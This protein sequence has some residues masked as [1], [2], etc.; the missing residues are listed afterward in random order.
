[1]KTVFL[2]SLLMTSLLALQGQSKFQPPLNQHPSDKPFLF[3]QLPEKFSVPA[4][5]LQSIFSANNNSGIR[6]FLSERLHIEGVVTARRAI[7]PDQLSINIRCTNYQDALLNLSRIT[8]ADGTY[9]YIGR[10]VSLR[11]GDV[12]LLWAD[13][14]QY[15]FVRQKQLLAMVE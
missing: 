1:M 11:H 8:G 5:A 9:S 15:S 12:L 13:K 7:G 10:M 14:G 6:V 4:A 2:W 3:S